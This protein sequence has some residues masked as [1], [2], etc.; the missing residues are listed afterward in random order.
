MLENKRVQ[1]PR[2]FWISIAY[3]RASTVDKSVYFEPIFYQ[4][5]RVET[6]LI[7][8]VS[9]LLRLGPVDWKRNL[10]FCFCLI[11]WEFFKFQI[12]VKKCRKLKFST[13][14]DIAEIAIYFHTTSLSFWILK[15]NC[16]CHKLL[17]CLTHIELLFESNPV[18]S[19]LLNQDFP[20]LSP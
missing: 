17:T 12:V 20:F 3:F 11:F 4:C 13:L 5:S 19:F 7:K 6:M 14:F 2:E 9:K 8:F 10:W 1:K 15:A 16:I 18:A